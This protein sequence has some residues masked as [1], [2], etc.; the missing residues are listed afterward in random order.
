MQAVALDATD[1]APDS[2][3]E[4]RSHPSTPLL[5]RKF[6][7]WAPPEILGQ[8]TYSEVQYSSRVEADDL[9]TRG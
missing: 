3:Q 6:L 8:C 2:A 9:I 5:N 7:R 4:E 1:G